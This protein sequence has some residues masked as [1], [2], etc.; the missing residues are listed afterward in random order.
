MNS[1]VKIVVLIV[2][3]LIILSAGSGLYVDWLWFKDLGYENLFW[4]PLLSKLTIQL[5]NGT[6]LFILITATLLSGRHALTTFYNERFRRR[7]HLVENRDRP[8]GTP[9]QRRITISLLLISAAVS[10]IVSII[11]GYTG[12]LNVISFFNASSFNYTDPLFHKDLSFYVFKLPFLQ[13]IYQ[14]FFSPVIILTF[15]TAVFYVITG[16]IRFY[17]VRIWKKDAIVINDN[18][19]KHLG[20]LF[21]FLFVLTGFGYYL[22]IYQLVYSQTGHVVG[23]GYTDIHATLPALKILLVLCVISVIL[24]LLVIFIKDS[25][26]LTLPVPLLI[27]FSVLFNGLY[28]SLMQSL[29]VIP[30]ELQKESPYI[31][32]EIKLTRFAYG[33]EN[34]EEKDYPGNSEIKAADLGKEVETLNNIRINDPRTMIQSYTQKQGIR[35]YY[36]FNDVDTDRYTINGEYRQV[37]LSAREISSQDLDEK[38]QT[39]VNTKFKYTHGFGV[40]ASFAN[41]V[42]SKGLPSFAVSNIPPQSNY[43]ELSIT[44]PRIY[45]GELT[46]DWV[47]VNT[48][49]KEFDY[50]R[51]TDIAENNYQGKTGL[52]FTPFNKMMLSLSRATPRFYLAKEVTPESKLLLY[53]NILERVKKLAPFLKYDPDPYLVIDNGR[54]KWIIDAYTTAATMPYSSQYSNDTFN[55]IRNSVK[56][57]VDAYDGTVDFYSLDQ[58]DPVLQTYQKTF[59]G[60]F[61]DISEMPYNL[62]THLRYP[63]TMFNIQCEML[64]NFHMTNPGVFYNKEDAWSIAKEIYDA[65]PTTVEPYYVIM[66]LPGESNPEFILMEAF[67]PA[68]SQTNTRNNL[69]AWLS[70]RM[71][72]ENYGKLVLYKLPKNVEIDGPFQIESRIDQDTEI[73]RQL[74]IWNQKGSSVMRG[75]LLTLPIKDNFLF[76]EPIYLKSTNT[77]SIPEMKRIV[78]SYE[79][80]LVMSPTLEEALTEIFGKDIPWLTGHKLAPPE[81]PAG[82]NEETAPADNNLTDI[83]DQIKKIRDMLDSL[84]NQVTE[85]NGGTPESTD[86]TAN[87]SESTQDSG[88]STDLQK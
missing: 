73:S 48:Q 58:N 66:K 79:D 46:N 4:I 83:L 41:T 84:E 27:L 30:N 11:V 56:V 35:A 70:A 62:K 54:L 13:I 28:P 51:G 59:P 25:R 42:T 20:I 17:S 63:E 29:V 67:T 72:G 21:I 82:E 61:K 71:D 49:F 24:S 39:F 34:I 40:A 43:S 64:N 8:A 37:M 31:A 10:I 36:K 75:N 85:L 9:S 65:D 81:E 55:Y 78:V 76:V 45:F 12:W 50:P 26:F 77:D 53:R 3:A 32:N 5:I 80:K 44:E 7:I 15:F 69:V 6:I 87:Q 38:A 19:R 1:I 57:V 18:A 86:Q 68:S 14:A 16:V 60:V 2:V 22:N 47:V 88:G 74:A 23:A 52:T 33:L